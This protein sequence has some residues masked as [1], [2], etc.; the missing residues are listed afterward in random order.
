MRSV[1][2]ITCPTTGDLVQTGVTADV[3]DELRSGS[4]AT[5]IRRRL[6]A[7][8]AKRYGNSPSVASWSVTNRRS[9][10]LPAK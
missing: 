3:L 5:T 8:L 1:V 4:P 9:E 7:C 10:L 2:L 6:S